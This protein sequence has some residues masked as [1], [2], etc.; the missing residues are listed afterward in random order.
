MEIEM[1]L[2]EFFKQW[3]A[4]AHMRRLIQQELRAFAAISPEL[5]SD[6]GLF[7]QGFR[8]QAERLVDCKLRYCSGQVE[9]WTACSPSAMQTCQSGAG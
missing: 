4:R 9:G 6:I 7:P 2:N 8:D 3:R 1:A 5:Y